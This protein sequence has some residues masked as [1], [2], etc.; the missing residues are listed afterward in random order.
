MNVLYDFNLAKGDI[1]D[2]Q[3]HSWKM[4]RNLCISAR[5][6]PEYEEVCNNGVTFVVFLN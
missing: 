2:A 1:I 5:N 3:G 4:D 6:I